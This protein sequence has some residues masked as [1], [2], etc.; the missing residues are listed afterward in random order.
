MFDIILFSVTFFLIFC[1]IVCFIYCAICEVKEDN[2]E[3]E[4]DQKIKEIKKLNLQKEI[5]NGI[6]FYGK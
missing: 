4:L 2:R 6:K 5:K 3:Y 1:L